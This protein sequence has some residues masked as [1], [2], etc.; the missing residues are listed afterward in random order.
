VNQPFIYQEAKIPA[1]RFIKSA[2]MDL[3]GA[4]AIGNNPPSWARP[5]F[6]KA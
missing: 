3:D 5:H 4:A 6:K 2:E 1:A